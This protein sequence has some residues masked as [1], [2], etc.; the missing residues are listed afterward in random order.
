MDGEEI[1]SEGVGH[2]RR[3]S[4]TRAS[5]ARIPCKLA[6][7]AFTTFTAEGTAAR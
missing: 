1:C 4:R 5:R 2:R 3:V 6:L 7:F